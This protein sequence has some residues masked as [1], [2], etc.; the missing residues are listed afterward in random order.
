V[1][2]VDDRK[3]LHE[4]GAEAQRKNKEKK[5]EGEDLELTEDPLGNRVQLSENEL[6]EVLLLSILHQMHCIGSGI[7][8]KFRWQHPPLEIRV[9]H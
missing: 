6:N 4:Q 2:N 1:T 7:E 9:T 5:L 3:S 8:T